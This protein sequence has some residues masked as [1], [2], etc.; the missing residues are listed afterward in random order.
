LG[1]E[2]S[3]EETECSS[4]E[5][6]IS[7]CIICYN[8]VPDHVMLPCGHGG[9]CGRCVRGMCMGRVPPYKVRSGHECPVCRAP[10]DTVAKVH[11]GTRVGKWTCAESTLSVQPEQ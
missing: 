1:S 3:E 7:T 11:L 4:K 9:F 5:S 6:S 2:Q 10:V 8:G